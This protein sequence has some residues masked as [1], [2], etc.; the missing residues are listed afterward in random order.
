MSVGYIVPDIIYQVGLV[1]IVKH[2][3]FLS[4]VVGQRGTRHSA[5]DEILLINLLQ[6]DRQCL[7]AHIADR[8]IQLIETMIFKHEVFRKRE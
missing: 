2:F 7:I 6:L 3:G 8:L 4:G 1:D 5:I